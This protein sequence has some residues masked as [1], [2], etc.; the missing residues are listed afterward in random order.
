MPAID[1]FRLDNKIAL[2]S[3]GSRGIGEAIAHGLAE[4]GAHVIV[5]SRKLEGCE[6]VAAAIRAQGGQATAM[7][8]HAGDLEAID[9]LFAAI[10]QQFGGLDILINNGGTNPYFGPVAETPMAAFDKTVEV[11]FRGPFY[12]SEKAVASMRTRGGGAILN[13][14]SIDGISAGALQ[15]VYSTTK[16][17]MISMTQAFALENGPYNIRV[18]ALCPG[19]TETRFTTVFM[20]Q[21]GYSDVVKH[22][23]LQRAAQPIDMVGATLLMVSDA[24]ACMTGQTL[25]VDSG[26]LISHGLGA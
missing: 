19:L 26:S 18:N 8:C 15:G 12:M 10:D 7:A 1:L 21:E 3:G 17:A 22:L 13:V 16:A 4:Q 25:V 20:E 23:P 14:A 9:A 2:V 5:S 11:N 6:A 24:G